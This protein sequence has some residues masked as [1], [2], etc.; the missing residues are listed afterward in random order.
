MLGMLAEGYRIRGEHG[1]YTV[2]RHFK[3]GGFGEL[4]L[5]SGDLIG[6]IPRLDV[7]IQVGFEKV[8]GRFET[9]K[10]VLKTVK[11]ERHVVR[12][13]DF[14]YVRVQGYELPVI[15]MEFV[16][17][18]TLRDYVEKNGPLEG[19][20]ALLFAR[21]LLEAVRSVNEKGYVLRDLKPSNIILRGG[22]PSDPVVVDFGCA[23]YHE[24]TQ[25]P[26]NYPDWRISSGS[27]T[28]PDLSSK[29]GVE[30]YYDVYSYGATLYYA[31]TGEHPNNPEFRKC[32]V[33]AEVVK[34]CMLGGLGHT[35]QIV[36][37]GGKVRIRVEGSEY[38]FDVFKCGGKILI[39]RD[40]S[41]LR[42]VAVCGDERVTLADDVEQYISRLPEGHLLVDVARMKV[43]RLGKNKPA[44]Y[45]GGRW[46][47]V[48]GE[49]AIGLRERVALSYG[50]VSGTTYLEMELAVE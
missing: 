48:R 26:E 35:S 12:F 43:V 44:L 4:Y 15:I 32:G 17:G 23:L 11:G 22:D 33:F 50:E 14:G 18:P 3:T 8:R 27:Y 45:R 36:L 40:R 20:S 47:V 10:G 30:F 39:G 7:V 5:L 41:S 13:V 2:L 49:E 29:G 16:K 19:R 9:E 37:P 1:E 24:V 34:K 42:V 6:K 38:T 21:A 25:L 28:H 46:V 31:L